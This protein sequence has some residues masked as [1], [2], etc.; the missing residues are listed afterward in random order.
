VTRVIAGVLLAAV[1]VAALVQATLSEAQVECEVCMDF[2]GASVCR[3]GSAAD[4][5]A[6]VRNAVMTACAVLS[7]GVTQGIACD[8]TPP[9]SV[10][11]EE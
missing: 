11:C 10:R 1:F 3:T 2:H 8:R 5:D 6:S 4:R 7:D 9:R